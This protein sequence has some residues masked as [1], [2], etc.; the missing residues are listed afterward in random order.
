MVAKL[1]PR[2][3]RP[4]LGL[5]EGPVRTRRRDRE[6]LA[7]SRTAQRCWRGDVKERVG[8]CLRGAYGPRVR[9]EEDGA[10]VSTFGGDGEEEKERDLGIGGGGK[11]VS[12][13]I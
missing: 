8:Y 13:R 11:R 1:R 4:L 3:P 12:A 2:P 10:V 9:G 6:G 5:P 7:L